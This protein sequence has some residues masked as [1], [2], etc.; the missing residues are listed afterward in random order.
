MAKYCREQAPL[1]KAEAA[2]RWLKIAGEYDKLA[3]GLRAQTQ[4]KSEDE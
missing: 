2:A 4:P 1:L 3:D